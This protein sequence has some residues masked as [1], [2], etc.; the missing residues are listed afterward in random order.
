[1][2]R[3]RRQAVASALLGVGVAF[4]NALALSKHLGADAVPVSRKEGR[5]L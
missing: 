4:A 2:P 3:V 5:W 1:M